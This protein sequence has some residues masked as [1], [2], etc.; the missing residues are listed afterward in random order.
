MIDP[1]GPDPSDPA[2]P[3]RHVGEIVS[4]FEPPQPPRPLQP[5]VRFANYDRPDASARLVSPPESNSVPKSPQPQP[6]NAKTSRAQASLPAPAD[7][8]PT[9]A[10]AAPAV[11][12]LARVQKQPP[13]PTK[14]ERALGV[15]R[16]VLPMV[17]KMLP[18]LEGNV[19]SAAANLMSGRPAEVNLKPLEDAIA[20]LQTDQRA[21][22]FHTSEH[23]R[24]IRRLEDELVAVQ[25]SVQKNAELQAELIEQ[26]AKQAKRTSSFMRL[27]TVLLLLSILFTALLCVRI[28]YIIRF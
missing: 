15:A 11:A 10:A 7:P 12:A 28:A 17:G 22:G 5:K 3:P 20:G 19:V 1:L 24:A 21:L 18:L 13:K 25:E 6:A 8:A 9:A 27:V 16:T 2:Q 26:V 14:L 23:K 4:D